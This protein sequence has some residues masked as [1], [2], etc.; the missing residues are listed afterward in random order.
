MGTWAHIRQRPKPNPVTLLL[1]SAKLGA[2]NLSG[3]GDDLLTCLPPSSELHLLRCLS[4]L[5]TPASVTFGLCITP[6]ECFFFFLFSFSL[7]LSL[8]GFSF[9]KKVKSSIYPP[10]NS[11][12]VENLPT[13]SSCA[14]KIYF[15]RT[16][17]SVTLYV[18]PSLPT[19]D[20]D[21][22]EKKS[23]VQQ[24]TRLIHNIFPI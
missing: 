17:L 20:H 10:K 3:A 14:N 6:L 8:T 13:F 9:L 5:V 2:I 23:H 16:R 15:Y 24:R 22:T 18:P 7:F 19:L 4:N 11:A 21:T 1:L 12:S